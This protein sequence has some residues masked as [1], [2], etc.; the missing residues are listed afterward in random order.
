MRSDL[1]RSLAGYPQGCPL[2]DTLKDI[3]C[4]QDSSFENFPATRASSPSRLKDSRIWRTPNHPP[5]HAADFTANSS[6]RAVVQLQFPKPRGSTEP[7]P[8]AAP[9]GL[10]QPKKFCPRANLSLPRSSRPSPRGGSFIFKTA[11][12]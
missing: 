3:Q 4:L 9:R 8:W 12:P 11:R 1:N 10:L 6:R 7:P 2:K 5:A